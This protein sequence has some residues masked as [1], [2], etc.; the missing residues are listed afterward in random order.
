M[1]QLSFEALGT[2]WDIYLDEDDTENGSLQTLQNELYTVAT[3]FEK[4]YSRFDPDSLI[5]NYS[6]KKETIHTPEFA[7]MLAFG[8]KLESVSDG[9]FTLHSGHVLSLLG[10]GKGEQSI[11]FGSFGK[12]WLVDSLAKLLQSKKNKKHFLINA[13]GDIFATKK[14]NGNSWTVALEHPTDPTRALATVELRNQALAA[15]SPFKRRW[16]KNNHLIDGKTSKSITNQRSV[17][18]LAANATIADGIATVLNII[19]KKMIS[20]VA[21]QFGTEYLILEDAV[22]QSKH[23]NCTFLK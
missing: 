1:Q 4:K 13:G 14:Q 6:D 8:K 20:T 19:P 5:N 18:T 3:S 7:S 22:Q 11:D 12:G 15:S 17:F 21:A 2:K 16:K 23:F 9:F 10:Y